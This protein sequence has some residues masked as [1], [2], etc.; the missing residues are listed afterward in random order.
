MAT[1]QPAS[2]KATPKSAYVA[3]SIV[4]VS[5]K[6]AVVIEINM[7]EDDQVIDVKKS[8]PC[9]TFMAIYNQKRRAAELWTKA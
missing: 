3:M 2:P 5:M 1:K 6:E 9:E 4:P 8:E 7:T